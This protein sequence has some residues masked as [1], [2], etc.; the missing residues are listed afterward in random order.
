MPAYAADLAAIRAA[1]NDFGPRALHAHLQ[2][3]SSMR[4]R[5]CR[6]FQGE[7]LQRIGAFKFRGVTTR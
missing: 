6:F 4:S 1:P 5:K 2:S 7:N 3:R